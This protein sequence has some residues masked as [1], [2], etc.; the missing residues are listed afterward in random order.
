MEI[1]KVQLETDGR[2]QRNHFELAIYRG[3]LRLSDVPPAVVESVLIGSAWRPDPDTG[4]RLGLCT[5]DLTRESKRAL[6]KLLKVQFVRVEPSGEQIAGGAVTGDRLNIYLR[7]GRKNRLIFSKTI[8]ASYAETIIGEPYFEA[9][10]V[11]LIELHR[12][13]RM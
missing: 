3:S 8:L 13:P 6:L 4:K 12:P 7:L 2:Y 10:T 1:K 9:E 5:D 11:V